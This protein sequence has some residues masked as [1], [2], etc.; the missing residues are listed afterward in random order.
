MSD[1]SITRYYS[2][3]PSVAGVPTAVT[4]N[5]T[6]NN[7]VLVSWTTPS[8]A[9]AGYEVFYQTASAGRLSGGNTSNSELTLTG[10]TLGETYSIFVVTYGAEGDPV[11]PSDHSNI[12]LIIILCE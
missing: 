12:A 10:L 11:L 9:P 6:G 5:R 8:L 4:A 2:P 3:P 7:S 1:Y